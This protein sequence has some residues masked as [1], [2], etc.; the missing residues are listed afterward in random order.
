[1]FVSEPDSLKVMLFQDSFEVANPLGSAKQKHKVLA[2]YFTL[3]NFY[4]HNRSTV[5]QIQLAL[6]CIEKD[7]KYFGVDRIFS[8]LV[9]DLCELEVKGISVE[10]KIYTGTVACI[11]GGAPT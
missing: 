6:L 10:G 11:M 2:V 5:D 1:M 9:S 8:K 3:R 7:C 4:P